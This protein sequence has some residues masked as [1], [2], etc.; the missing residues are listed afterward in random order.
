MTEAIADIDIERLVRIDQRIDASESTALRDRWEFGHQMIAARIGSKLPPGYLTQLVERTGKSRRELA[1]RAQ[2]A[3]SYPTED[4]LCNALHNGAS[5]FEIT[6]S[7]KRSKDADDNVP[8]QP[9]PVT[10]GEFR[11]FVAD[12]PWQYGNTST[13]GAAENHY[14]TMTI[15]ELCALDVV[16]DSAADEAHLYLWTTAGHLPQAF[17]VMSAWGFEYKT[18][19][20]WCKP[21]I[22]MGNYFRISTELVL[23]GV[24]GGMRTQARDIRNW[25]EAK[26]GKHSAKPLEFHDLVIKASPGPY[27]ELFSRCSAD[28]MLTGCTCSKCRLGWEVWGNQAA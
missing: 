12:P 13:R 22:G 1:Y 6:Q 15:E 19:L 11:T 2:F 5:W 10:D 14:D 26:R 7:L 24:K 4:A 20:V 3:E 25:F 28:K 27:M 23:F 21:Q 17:D 18:Y 8:V 16:R 9:Q